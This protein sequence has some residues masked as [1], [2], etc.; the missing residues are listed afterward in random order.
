[1]R[2]GPPL[3]YLAT[4]GGLAL[5]TRSLLGHTLPLSAALGCLGG[6]L[7][8]VAL[9]VA[10]PQLQMWGEAICTGSPARG[11]ALTFDDG[12]HPVHTRAVARQLRRFKARATFFVIGEKAIAHPDVLHELI[13]DGHEIGVHGHQVDRWLSLRSVRAAHDDLRRCVEAIE[14]ITKKRPTLFRPPYGLTTPRI[15]EAAADLDLDLIAWS[16]RALDGVARTTGEQVRR[17]VIPALR[18]G[19]I[20]CLHD[21]PETGERTPVVIDELPAILSALHERN[22]PAVTVSELLVS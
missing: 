5:T 17:R 6:Y 20:I 4:A 10:F 16:A 1:M 12:P 9:G 13:D 8:L 11:V 22:L 14:R 7:G 18:G 3:L 21:A 19:A 15:L 2:L